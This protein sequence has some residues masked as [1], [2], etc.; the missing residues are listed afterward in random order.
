[1]EQILW[2]GHSSVILNGTPGAYFECRKGVRQGHFEGLGL[3]LLN[4]HKIMYIQ[5]AD[6]T[7]LFLKVDPI[8]IE[9]V[10]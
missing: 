5:Y 10:K 4:N 7:L 9:R 2:G 1:M 3:T 8:M 6:D